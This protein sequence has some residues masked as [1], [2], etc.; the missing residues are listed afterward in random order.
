[1]KDC[2]PYNQSARLTQIGSLGLYAPAGEGNCVQ[3]EITKE[4]NGPAQ[5]R[6]FLTGI[7]E[8]GRQANREVRRADCKLFHKPDCILVADEIFLVQ[9]KEAWTR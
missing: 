6:S 7:G 9:C 3:P 4:C 2:R 5:L 1:M 8:Y